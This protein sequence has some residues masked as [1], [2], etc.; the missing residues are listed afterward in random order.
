ME[1]GRG[2]G[3]AVDKQNLQVRK[4]YKRAS[5]GKFLNLRCIAM[6]SIRHLGILCEKYN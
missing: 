6:H 5:S 4:M 3:R 2:E 1:S